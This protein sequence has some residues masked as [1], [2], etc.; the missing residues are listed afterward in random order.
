[1]TSIRT[2]LITIL[3]CLINPAA[4]LADPICESEIDS[5]SECSTNPNSTFCQMLLNSDIETEESINRFMDS[6]KPLDKD[7]KEDL[8][9]ARLLGRTV[10]LDHTWT[11]SSSRQLDNGV[12]TTIIE[13]KKGINSDSIIY[14]SQAFYVS[15]KIYSVIDW[16]WDEVIS[17][18]SELARLDYRVDNDFHI[19]L[20]GRITQ[21]LNSGFGPDDYPVIGAGIQVEVDSWSV[22][23]EWADSKEDVLP[24][25]YRKRAEALEHYMQI[26][27]D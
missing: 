24:T 6:L 2:T 7:M 22:S 25:L 12:W 17:L 15:F 4:V 16:K 9:C 11:L 20:S 8:I 5:L 19:V 10:N 27:R 23:T 13:K 21:L 26:G 1:M 3:F 18:L 14:D